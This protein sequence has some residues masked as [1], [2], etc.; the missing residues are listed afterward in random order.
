M[1]KRNVETYLANETGMEL[2]SPDLGS[3]V[4][5][6]EKGGLLRD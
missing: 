5:A 6:A 4:A 1:V 3:E 2:I